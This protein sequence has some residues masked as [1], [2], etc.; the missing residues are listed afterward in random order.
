MDFRYRG[1][2][3]TCTV[4]PYVKATWLDPPEG[5]ECEDIEWKV[6]DIDEL[7]MHLELPTE[8]LDQM[9]RGYFKIMGRLPRTLVDKIDRTFDIEDACYEAA[10]DWDPTDEMDY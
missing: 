6:D 4:T 10:A 1:L 7:L 3:V 8:G 9:V 2:E 5:G